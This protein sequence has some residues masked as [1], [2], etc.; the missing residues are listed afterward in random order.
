MS[1]PANNAKGPSVPRSKAKCKLL[2][3]FKQIQWGSAKHQELERL[4]DKELAER[5]DDCESE[6]SHARYALWRR[7]EKEHAG[8]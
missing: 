1:A 6:A 2:M 4:S 8:N 3:E 5:A 7:L